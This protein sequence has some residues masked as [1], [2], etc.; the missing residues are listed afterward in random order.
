MEYGQKVW[1]FPDAECPPQGNGEIKG[2]ESLI[3]LNAGDKDAHIEITFYYEDREPVRIPEVT[4]KARRVRCMRTGEEKDFGEYTASE[5]V[6]Y[7]I[8]AVSDIPVVM[9]YGR[10][11]PRP[12][13]FY[14][15]LGYP[16]RTDIK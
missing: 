3:I 5:G 8:T 13:A 7:A 11:E 15:T 14:T 6:Q 1:V 10:A 16:C 2:H 9:Q 12:V 4:V